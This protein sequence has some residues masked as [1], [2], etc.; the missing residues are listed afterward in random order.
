M[1][2]FSSHEHERSRRGVDTFDGLLTQG[3]PSTRVVSSSDTTGTS[4]SISIDIHALPLVAQASRIFPHAHAH[5]EKYGD[6][7]LPLLF[8]F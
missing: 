3:A 6:Y 2:F 5:A 8:F 4:D 1:A 7:I